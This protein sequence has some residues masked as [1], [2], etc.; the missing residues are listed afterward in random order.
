DGT[1][2]P[3]EIRDSIT[4]VRAILDRSAASFD[5]AASDMLK[6]NQLYD[7]MLPQLGKMRTDIDAAESRLRARFAS[8]RNSADATIA[9]T[10]TVQ[11]AIG[12]LALMLGVL[13]ALVIARSIIRPVARLTETIRQLASGPT[14]A[15]I[16]G[17]EATDEIGMMARELEVFRQNAIE[18]VR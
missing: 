8:A 4:P 18:Q 16:P 17:R 12:T 6:I 5:A 11:E 13:L 2:L 10:I 7:E 15:A 14:E 3:G 9:T 1:S